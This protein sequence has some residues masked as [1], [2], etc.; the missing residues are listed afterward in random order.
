MLCCNLFRVPAIGVCMLALMTATV[1]TASTSHAGTFRAAN[2]SEV[3]NLRNRIRA[4][5]FLSKATFGPTEQTITELAIRIGQVGYRRACEEWIDEQFALPMTSQEQT[6][7]DIVRIDGRDPRIQGVGVFGYRPQGWWHI[8]LTSEDQLRQRVTWALAQIFVVGSGVSGFNQN[9][10]AEI[11]QSGGERTIPRW[12]GMCHYYDTLAANAF[13]NYRQLLGEVTYHANMGIWLSSLGNQKALIEGEG[14]GREVKR[15]PDENYAREIMQLFSIG[16][17]DLH[18][19]GRLKVDIN[20]DLIPSYDNFDIT[21]LAR[22]FTGLHYSDG[23]NNDN[24]FRLD[25]N[26]YR[27]YGDPMAVNGNWHDNNVDYTQDPNAPASKTILGVTLPPL[28]TNYDS[29]GNAARNAAAKQ[30]I[31]NALD[32]IADHP[33]VAPF[34]SRLLIQRLVK[35]NPSRAY[36]RRVTSKWENNGNGE[37]GDLKAVVKAI[38]LDPE[39]MR[40]QTIR[41]VRNGDG[42][43]AVSVRSRGTE[44]SRL[45]EPILRVSSFIRALR[46]TSDYA[47]GYM[48]LNNNIG[49]TVG[50]NPFGSP[51]VFNYYLPDYQ[52]V[53]LI[54]YTPSRR[55]PQTS[56]FTPE[57][58]I[59]NAVSSIATADRL[60]R[61]CRDRRVQYGMKVGICRI[62]LNLDPEL[63]MAADDSD[64]GNDYDGAGNK[65]NMKTLLERFDLLLCSGGLTEGTKRLIY[66]ALATA[67]GDGPIQND[68]RLEM[69]LL[70]IVT[71]PDCAVEQ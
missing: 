23:N 2:S 40:G 30:E 44:Y 42:T 58:Q 20:G 50:Q 9:Q 55:L 10:D 16:L 64:P 27:N 22:V 25:G 12:L 3:R 49:N 69:M 31:D 48:M 4:S 36:I 39:V 28:P 34:I 38:L 15:S 65:G 5:Q 32:V 57:F 14:L 61:F 71:S 41:R 13:G 1:I 67:A 68:H 17:Y 18:P 29:L 7:R 11:P 43:L 60:R 54:G 53:D 63:V 33:N 70:A 6:C 45:R 19:D 21:E 37:R 26:Q 8:A 56:L 62:T 47:G 52:S 66:N 51:T 35:S 24:N 59:L 46:P